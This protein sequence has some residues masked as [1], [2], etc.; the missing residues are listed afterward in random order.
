MADAARSHGRRIG[1]SASRWGYF[2][3]SLS[4]LVFVACSAWW[5]L[6]HHPL[7]FVW[8]PMTA[9]AL[10]GRRSTCHS[11]DSSLSHAHGRFVGGCPDRGALDFPMIQPPGLNP[12]TK[13]S[14]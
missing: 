14:S 12:T 10:L 8:V 4:V 2:L 5:L 1:P 13:Q 6:A 9:L 11:A 7:P 3:V